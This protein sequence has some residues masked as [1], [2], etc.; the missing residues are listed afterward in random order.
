[1]FEIEYKKGGY[2]YTAT[3]KANSQREALEIFAEKY[4]NSKILSIKQ[5]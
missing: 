5:I 1:M 3:I 2:K 4:K